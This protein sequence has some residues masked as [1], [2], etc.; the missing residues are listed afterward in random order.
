MFSREFLSKDVDE[1]WEY[2]DSLA[3]NSQ[4][5]KTEDMSMRS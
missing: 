2:L 3:E 5:Y 4:A 1:V